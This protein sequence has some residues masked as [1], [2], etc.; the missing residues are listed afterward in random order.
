[1]PNNKAPAAAL[2]RPGMIA[3]IVADE[4]M[5]NCRIVGVYPDHCVC[6]LIDMDDPDVKRLCPEVSGNL[7][8]RRWEDVLLSNV[9]PDLGK[10]GRESFEKLRP[11]RG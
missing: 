10:A 7:L 8:A 6:E 3:A 5:I 11:R 4:G 2:A 9:R 1:M